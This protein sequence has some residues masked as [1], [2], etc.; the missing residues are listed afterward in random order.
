MRIPFT[1]THTR[2]DR[3]RADVLSP[4]GE[5]DHEARPALE[6]TLDALSRPVGQVHLDMAR[7]TFMD[8]A[9]LHFLARLELLVGLDGG[10]LR[11][12]GLGAQPSRVVDLARTLPSLPD[13]LVSADCVR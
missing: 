13:L 4:A 2:S 8:S 11:V 12:T 3:G 9:G 1:V 10:R 6:R 5:I 7:V